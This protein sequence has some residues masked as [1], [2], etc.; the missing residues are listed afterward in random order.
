MVVEE[1]IMAIA[2][3][4][5]HKNFSKQDSLFN[6]RLFHYRIVLI[7]LFCS[8]VSRIY[9]QTKY[10]ELEWARKFLG[11]DTNAYMAKAFAI[12]GYGNSYIA[13]VNCNFS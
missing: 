1:T 12:D 2:S 7:V 5:L 9:A 6:Q 8:L 13:V 3:D 4:T 10:A 11:Y